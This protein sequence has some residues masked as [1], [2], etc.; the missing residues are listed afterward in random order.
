M[1]FEDFPDLN[2]QVFTAGHFSFHKIN[3]EVDVLVVEPVCYLDPNQ[4]TEFFHVYHKSGFRI[5]ISFNRYDQIKIMTM[6][7]IIG[8]WPEHLQV[9]FFRPRGVEEFVCC[10]K[11]FFAGNVN[12]CVKLPDRTIKKKASLTGCFLEKIKFN[13]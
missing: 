12:H 6:P 5:R 2:N 4:G 1:P 11:V 13:V 8:A 9:F 10:V 7:V 3:I